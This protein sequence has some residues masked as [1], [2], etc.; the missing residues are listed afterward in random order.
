MKNI[1][2]YDRLV[3]ARMVERPTTLD[4]IDKIFTNFFELHG[5]RLFKDDKSIVGGI[6]LLNNSPVTIIGIQKGKDLKENMD[7]NFG[8][9][10][11]E[12]Y[13]KA[14]RLMKQA[15][16]FNRPIVCFINT[17]GAYCGVG[18]EERGQGE[19]IAKNLIEIAQIKVPII[20]IIIGEGGSGGALAL[21]CGDRVWM[22]ENSVYSILSPE[23]FASILLKDPSKSKEV[24]EIM[25]I[26][27]YDLYE[28]GVIEKI[29]KEPK[30]GAHKSLD[31]I[32]VAIKEELIN[33]LRILS[34][35]TKEE[36]LEERYQRFRK[37]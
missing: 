5:D 24:A 8:S 7:R 15:E 36:L 31:L 4:Y 3:I 26:T 11:P 13:R 28:K 35:K 9:P 33:E 10:H 21:A 1:K 22:L 16:K 23:G 34:S 27:A 2:A 14:L 12:G 6:G 37:F 18:A 17:S 30:G 32:A 29:I 20:S 25:G 19:A